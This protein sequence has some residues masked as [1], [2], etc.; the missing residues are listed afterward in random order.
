M[1]EGA[2]GSILGQRGRR[3]GAVRYKDA[4]TARVVSVEERAQLVIGDAAALSLG[5]RPLGHLEPEAEHGLLE[6]LVVNR[7]RAVQVKL[8]KR[9]LETTRLGD[10]GAHLQNADHRLQTQRQQQARD[11]G[12]TAAAPCGTRRRAASSPAG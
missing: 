2:S 8:G 1:G 9:L 11:A 12:T 4:R 6:L 7:A 3:I 10:A 5:L